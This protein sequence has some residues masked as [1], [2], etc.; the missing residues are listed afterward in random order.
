[1]NTPVATLPD[2]YYAKAKVEAWREMPYPEKV[3]CSRN[4]ENVHQ[5]AARGKIIVPENLMFL[6]WTSGF[7]VVRPTFEN[8]QPARSFGR[9]TGL[10]PYTDTD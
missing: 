6:R 3:R 4:A 5:F 8:W 7:P 2:E 1:M 10:R 9:L